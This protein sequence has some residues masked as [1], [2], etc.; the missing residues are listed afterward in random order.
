MT[1]VIEVSCTGNV[2]S[3]V[4]IAHHHDGLFEKKKSAFFPPSSHWNF[5][6]AVLHM[7]QLKKIVGQLQKEHNEKLLTSKMLPIKR[8]SQCILLK[9][10]AELE[11]IPQDLLSGITHLKTMLLQLYINREV[12]V[13][14]TECVSVS[15]SE[16][17]CALLFCRLV[18]S[19]SYACVT[20]QIL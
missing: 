2:L 18:H 14:S 1:S 5:D 3:A 20:S 10:Q 15:V 4:V 17:Y 11:K 7:L 8:N 9:N 12:S 6:C 13:Q 19:S 16:K